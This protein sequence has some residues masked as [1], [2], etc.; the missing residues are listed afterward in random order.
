MITLKCWRFDCVAGVSLDTEIT[1]SGDYP[2]KGGFIHVGWH[3]GRLL[4]SASCTRHMADQALQEWDLYAKKHGEAKAIERYG[5]R[6][7]I[8][9]E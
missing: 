4:T 1:H 3:S 9:A 7:T 2:A 6:P 5:K 8:E